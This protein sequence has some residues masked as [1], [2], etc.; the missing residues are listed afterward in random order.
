MLQLRPMDDRVPIFNRLGEDLAPV[1]LV[2][3]FTV[4]IGKSIGVGRIYGVV[5][6]RESGPAGA[7]RCEA[8]GWDGRA[9]HASPTPELGGAWGGPRACWA[10]GDDGDDPHRGAACRARAL[11]NRG[12]PSRRPTCAPPVTIALRDRLF[13][14]NICVAR[15]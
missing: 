8:L 5:P 13:R 4:G 1:I 15:A 11:R 2:N 14:R 7:H 6:C 3:I 10:A 12:A 9:R